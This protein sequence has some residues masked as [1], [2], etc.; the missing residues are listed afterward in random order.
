MI[1]DRQSRVVA[2]PIG[3]KLSCDRLRSQRDR[4]EEDACVH[5]RDRPRISLAEQREQ[6]GLAERPKPARERLAIEAPPR[7][8]THRHE[9]Q[10][11]PHAI[12]R[13]VVAT[14]QQNATAVWMSICDRID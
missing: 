2:N 14:V 3:P 12:S 1:G 7:P 10:L 6:V 5:D 4:V 9:V 13:K 8:L 11:R